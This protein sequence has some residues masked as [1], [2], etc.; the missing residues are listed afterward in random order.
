MLST[1]LATYC[2]GVNQVIY[3]IGVSAS[4]LMPILAVTVAFEVFSRYVLGA[5]T[6]WAYD[7]SLF[8]FGYIAALGGAL[9]QQKKAH[10][11]VDVLYLSVSM[12]VR[13]L[14]NLFSYSLA[15][16]FLAVVLMMALG[17]FEEAVEFNYRRQSEWAPSMA[18]FWVMMVVAC[19]AFIVQFTSDIVQD[20]YYLLTGKSLIEQTPEESEESETLVEQAGDL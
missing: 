2:R 8:L 16:F 13:S 15:I 18:H 14:F 4:L 12:R 19:G 1:V 3:W 9:A 7:V 10:I 6:I 17:K 5:P 20:L 11:N